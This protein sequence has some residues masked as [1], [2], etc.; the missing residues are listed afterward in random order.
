MSFRPFCLLL[1]GISLCLAAQSQSSSSPLEAALQLLVERSRSQQPTRASSA[2]SLFHL[3]HYYALSALPLGVRCRDAQALVQ[4]LNQ[5][6]HAPTL[7]TPHYL[8]LRLPLSEL[9]WLSA[10]PGIQSISL[11]RKHQL[12]LAR[13][14]RDARVEALHQGT[15]LETPF[16]GKGVVLGI[17]DQGFDFS[18]PAFQ[19]PQRQQSRLLAF[20]DHQHAAFPADTLPTGGQSQGFHG[21]H[22]ANIAAG[23]PVGNGYHGVAPEADLVFVSSSLEDVELPAEVSYVKAQAEAQGKPWVVNMSFGSQVGSHDGLTKINQALA[24]LT[25]PG[26]LIAAAMGNEGQERRHSS[27]MLQAGQAKYLLLQRQDTQLKQRNYEVASVDL[28]GQSREG[29][30][31]LKVTPFLYYNGKIH[32]QDEAFWREHLHQ[33]LEV[34]ADNGKSHAFCYF[35]NPSGQLQ[36]RFR[37]SP[38]T[39][40]YSGLKIELSPAAPEKP[41]PLHLWVDQ[42]QFAP[43]LVAGHTAHTLQADHDYQVGEGGASIPT[44]IAVGAYNTSTTVYSLSKQAQLHAPEIGQ[45]GAR[46]SFSNRGPFLSSRYPKPAVLAPGAL[47]VSALNRHDRQFSPTAQ[48]ITHIVSDAQGQKAYY[49][50]S[51]GTSMASPF[52]AGVLCLWLQANPTLDYAAVM[53]I[54]RLTSRRDGFMGSEEW[55]AERGYGKIDAYAGLQEA[56]RRARVAGIDHVE[57]A[58]Q[59]FSV[60]KE[61][62]QWRFLFHHATRRATLRVLNASG[63]VLYSTQW[64]HIRQGDERVLSLSSLASG[65]YIVELRTPTSSHTFRCLLP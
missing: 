27:T 19:H 42:G 31:R 34:N 18:H 58:H 43:V 52:V 48:H 44:A 35:I 38:H 14:R 40:V 39:R 32:E 24:Q 51:Q 20:W 60:Q 33:T 1:V 26:A 12:H 5:R 23:T 64:Q 11:A 54:L 4:Q 15:Q 6:G 45:L 22:V 61:S 16:T 57:Q 65:L 30:Q 62:Q 41:E 59:P 36:N 25:G 55:N 7:I 17:I 49:G 37:L 21:T 63:Q 29:G 9:S 47:I 53:D 8:S 50:F 3:G 13:A 2:D 46:S 10:L 56:L 28:W